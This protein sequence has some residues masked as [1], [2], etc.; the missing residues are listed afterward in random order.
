[1]LSETDNLLFDEED[2]KNNHTDSKL[3]V[4]LCRSLHTTRKRIKMV[5]LVVMN[6]LHLRPILLKTYKLI[7]I[8]HFN[9]DLYLSSYQ[10]PK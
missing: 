2:Q 5:N 1:M 6:T 4:M 3:S 8:I 7:N 9:T 10:M